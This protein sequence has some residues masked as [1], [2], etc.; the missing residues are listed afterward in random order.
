MVFLLYKL[1]TVVISR[2]TDQY[3]KAHELL[4]GVSVAAVKRPR[5]APMFPSTASV[6][7]PAPSPRRDA[8][9]PGGPPGDL[10]R[11]AHCA[12]VPEGARAGWGWNKMA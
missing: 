2:R 7:P 1:P 10:P 4:T 9:G 12:S 5:T 3:A 8:G 6:P 11:L